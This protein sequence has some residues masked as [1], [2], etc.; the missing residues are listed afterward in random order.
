MKVAS[1]EAILN[2]LNENDV[3]YL[4]VGGLAVAAHGYG[5]LTFD[6]DLVLQLQRDN[7]ARAIKALESLGYKSLVPVPANAFADEVN[8]QAWIRE[9]N[10]VVFQ[11]HSDSHRDTP[12]D[13][14]VSEPFDFDEEYAQAATGEL[15]P[16]LVARFVRLDT[17]IRMKEAAGR[18]KDLEDVR[19]LR[20]LQ[21]HP[22]DDG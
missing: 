1:L 22:E 13:L 16:G 4:I 6:L 9:K 2:V 21:E 7:V 17:L 18:E 15:L 11:L 19:Q 20:L 5:R 14:F 8:R 3:R 10:M 12:I